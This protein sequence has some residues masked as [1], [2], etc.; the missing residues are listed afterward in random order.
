M[1]P[2]KY[3]ACFESK[4]DIGE[5]L[6]NVRFTTKADIAERDCDVHFVPKADVSLL[7]FPQVIDAVSMWITQLSIARVTRKRFPLLVKERTNSTGGTKE[8]AIM[9]CHRDKI[10][11]DPLLRLRSRIRR[12]LQNLDELEISRRNKI[13]LNVDRTIFFVPGDTSALFVVSFE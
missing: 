12:S 8:Q 6:H 11:I 2:M 10:A 7:D 4:A 3:D 5:C 9:A 13:R 1:C